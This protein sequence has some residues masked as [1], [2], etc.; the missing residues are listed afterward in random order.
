MLKDGGFMAQLLFSIKKVGTTDPPPAVTLSRSTVDSGHAPEILSIPDIRFG[1]DQAVVDLH[2]LRS[3][4]RAHGHADA[5]G[6]MGLLAEEACK[7]ASIAM[8]R[9][10]T[11]HDAYR[12]ILLG[13]HKIVLRPLQDR[14]ISWS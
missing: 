3:C 13:D 10:P 5:P 14:S 1:V 8:V 11:K 6:M 9:L 4:G 2:G 12:R 7:A